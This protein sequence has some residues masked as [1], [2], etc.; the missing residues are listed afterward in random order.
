MLKHQLNTPVTPG[1]RFEAR[2]R[3][4]ATKIVAGTTDTTMDMTTDEHGTELSSLFEATSR[5]HE[6]GHPHPRGGPDTSSVYT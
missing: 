4:R 3:R 6:A 1:R 5:R 2:C